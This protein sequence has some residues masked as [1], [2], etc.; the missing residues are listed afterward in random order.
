MRTECQLCVKTVKELRIITTGAALGKSLLRAT[1]AFRCAETI[2]LSY[3]IE[4]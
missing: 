1:E 2:D 4:L 3:L